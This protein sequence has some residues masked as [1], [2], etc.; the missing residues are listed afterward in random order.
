[1][2]IATCIA[3]G[4]V[5]VWLLMGITNFSLVR[6]YHKPLFCIGKELAD[7]GGSGMYIGLG[8]SFDIEGNFMPEAA[9][10]GV[11]SYRGYLFGNEVC[12]GFWEELLCYEGRGKFNR[13]FDRADL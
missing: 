4:A 2:R 6:N 7:D 5:A 10:A 1:M 12:I 11:T 8:Y 3:I 13:I 9:A